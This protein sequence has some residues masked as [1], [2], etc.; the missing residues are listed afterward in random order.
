MIETLC[1]WQM[2]SARLQD[3]F[4]TKCALILRN[5]AS[6]RKNSTKI[7]L[8]SICFEKKMCQTFFFL[9]TEGYFFSFGGEIVN[10][11]SSNQDCVL[12]F[13]LQTLG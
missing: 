4:F 10:S 3:N 12:C 1:C 8:L 13:L 7:L 9:M 6:C 11:A 2:S 5:F